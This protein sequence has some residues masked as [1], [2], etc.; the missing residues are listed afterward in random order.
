MGTDLGNDNTFKE[1]GEQM[2]RTEFEDFEDL[3]IKLCGHNE[4]NS[5][6]RRVWLRNHRCDD[7]DAENTDVNGSKGPMAGILPKARSTLD[8][9]L[10]GWVCTSGRHNQAGEENVETPMQEQECSPRALKED[11]GLPSADLLPKHR[12]AATPRT[13]LLATIPKG[14]R[15]QSSAISFPTRQPASLSIYLAAGQEMEEKII[16]SNRLLLPEI[17]F[18]SRSVTEPKAAI[19]NSCSCDHESLVLDNILAQKDMKLQKVLSQLIIFIEYYPGQITI[20]EFNVQAKKSHNRRKRVRKGDGPPQTLP[21]TDVEERVAEFISISGRPTATGGTDPH[22]IPED[23]QPQAANPWDHPSTLGQHVEE[24]EFEEEE[25]TEQLTPGAGGQMQSTPLLPLANASSKDDLTF[26]GFEISEVPGISSVQQR[27]SG[28]ESRMP[29]LRKVS[30]QSRSADRQADAEL[31]MVGLSRE[32]IQLTRH[33]LDVLGRI[34]ATIQNLTATVTEVGSQIVG[35]SCETC[36]AISANTRP[37]ASNSHTGVLESVARSLSEFPNV[38]PRHTPTLPVTG[39]TDEEARLSEAGP[40][41]PRACPV[42]PQA[43]SP[44]SL[45][46]HSSALT[47]L[48]HA[49]MVPLWVQEADQ[50]GAKELEANPDDAEE[51]SDEDKPEEQNIVQPHLPDQEHG[52]IIDIFEIGMELQEY[53]DLQKNRTKKLS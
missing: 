31:D 8:L 19:D 35:V 21:P 43:A 39:N 11:F 6:Q 7:G 48:L 17:P 34:P 37:V 26:P 45:P 49:I 28:V 3:G 42:S 27:S 38:T 20:G 16:S 9:S 10:A 13:R 5:A 51:D 23:D 2:E 12:S 50:E 15:L 32:N 29:S 22:L 33:L 30:H 44:L 47:T 41:T 18:L 25:L 1:F 24:E 46:Q 52:D 36:E 40:S 14:P 4:D 53:S